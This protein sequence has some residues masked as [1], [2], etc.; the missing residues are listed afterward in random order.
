MKHVPM[1]LALLAGVAFAQEEPD[2]AKLLND[3][4]AAN[5]AKDLT[6]IAGLLDPI[7]KVGQTAKDNKAVDG[8]AKELSESYKLCK[9]NWGTLRKIV[10]T[11]GALRSKQGAKLLKKVAFQDDVTEADEMSVQIQALLA[12]G[13]L[14][15]SKYIDPIVDQCKNRETTIADAAYQALAHYGVAKGKTRKKVAEEL[16]KRLEAEYPYNTSKDSTA[17]GE[18]AVK[19]WEA[20]QMTIVKSMQGVCHEP[21]I[22]SVANWR[23]WWKMNKKSSKAWKDEKS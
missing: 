9:G 3:L 23:E 20:L 22:T 5:K 7:L 13:M 19:R 16:M 12:I 8:L 6:A 21:T 15:D 2:P 1:I 11:L 17:P 18:A 14:A 4:A 10:D